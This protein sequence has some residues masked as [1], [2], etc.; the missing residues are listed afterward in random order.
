MDRIVTEE[1]PKRP[2]SISIV[3]VLALLGAV[4]SFP[5]VFS[6]FSRSVGSWFPPY[7]V[8]SSLIGAACFVGLWFMKKWAVYTYIGYI[9]FSN[10]ALFLLEFWV[11]FAEIIPCIVIIV[12]LSHIPKMS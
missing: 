11:P 6:E 4:F 3:C 9:A 1:K 12:A 8:I 10:I 7:L 2:L 5:A